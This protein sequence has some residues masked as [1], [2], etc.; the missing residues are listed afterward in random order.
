MY[1]IEIIGE[2]MEDLTNEVLRYLD[3]GMIP[4][5]YVATAFAGRESMIAEKFIEE[6]DLQ[7]QIQETEETETEI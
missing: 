4:E 1:N 3:T 7:L 5:N 6:L 2:T